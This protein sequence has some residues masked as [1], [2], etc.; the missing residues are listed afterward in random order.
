MGQHKSKSARSG[1]LNGQTNGTHK[2]KKANKKLLEE[3]LNE[4]ESK[5]YCE[6]LRLLML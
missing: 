6:F 3:E 2:P 4:L 5:T 1:E